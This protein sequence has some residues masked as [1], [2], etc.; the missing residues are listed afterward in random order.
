MKLRSL[1]G[2]AAL[3]VGAACTDT[4][5]SPSGHTQV[6]LTDSPFPYDDVSRVEVFIEEVDGSQSVDTTGT[7]SNWVTIAQPQAAFNLLQLQRGSTAL[8]GSAELPAGEYRALRMTI[9][10][11]RSHVYRPNGDEVVVHWPQTPT[12]LI[13]MHAL[14]EDPLAVAPGAK[15]VIDFDVGRSFLVLESSPT[16]LV[17]SPWI[18]AVNDAATGSIGG[19]VQWS[20][21]IDRNFAVVMANASIEAFTVRTGGQIGWVAATGRTDAQGKYEITYLREGTYILVFRGQTPNGE[22]CT[23]LSDLL[24][25]ARNETVANAVAYP[26][27]GCGD[28]PRPDSTV[29]R[30]DSLPTSGGPVATV[31]V[32]VWQTLAPLHVGDSVGA[33]AELLDAGGAVLS[34][35]PV[36]WSVDTSMVSIYGVVGPHLIMRLKHVGTVV[37][38]ATSEGKSGL[39]SFL[40]EAAPP[41]GNPV[42]TVSVTLSGPSSPAVNDSVIATALLKDAG[43]AT[44][45]GR[46]VSWTIADSSVVRSLGVFGQQI[47]LRGLKAGSTVVTANAEGYLGSATVVVH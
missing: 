39:T 32:R 21:D 26:G 14:V 37:V 45:T 28:D 31:N 43:G 38:H 33:Y 15:I 36:T 47:V 30:P 12:G 19:L 7:G 6:L 46:V 22:A 10:P 42:A 24:V 41:P 11:S 4:S 23:T 5:I 29:A 16:Q 27:L 13:V 17:F 34:G 9:D 44:L 1:I 40:V 2:A 20:T 8:L 18:R 35:R 25:V 3:L